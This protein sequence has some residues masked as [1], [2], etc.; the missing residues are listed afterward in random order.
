MNFGFIIP[1]CIKE[2]L[3]L[4]Q[5]LRCIKSIRKYYPETYIILINDSNDNYNIYKILND[6]DNID[7]INIDKLNTDKLNADNLNADKINMNKIKI[8]K[9]IKKGSADQ[10]I[11]KHFNDTNLFD[12]AIF[13]QDSM[14]LNKKLENIDDIKDIKFI[15]HFTNHRIH[16]DLINEPENYFNKENNIITHTDL[17]KYYI[18]NDFKDN[19]NFLNFAI[20]NLKNKNK[21]CGSLGS[22]CIITKKALKNLNDNVNFIDK[23]I[24]YNTNRL[25]RVN[26]SIFPLI[27]HY[28]YPDINFENSYDSIY[29]DGINVNKYNGINTGFD[30]L[31][32]CAVN[33]YFSKI[34][35][36]R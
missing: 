29:Y 14:I 4:N 30:N 36:D 10:Q 25:R 8:I 16:W 2:N 7:K 23:F 31:K 11:F 22:C 5:L 27:C 19:E 6:I 26:E 28:V 12:K 20:E 15:W 35:F 33:N 3:H 17:I 9:S 1:I 32:W 24:N 21:W 13:I 34:S 18:L